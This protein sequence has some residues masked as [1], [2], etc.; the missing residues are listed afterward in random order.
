MQND[1]FSS[2]THYSQIY[3]KKRKIEFVCVC[4]LVLKVNVICVHLCLYVCVSVRER[5]ERERER[6]EE[7][8]ERKR[9]EREAC[10]QKRIYTL[11]WPLIIDCKLKCGLRVSLSGPIIMLLKAF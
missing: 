10:A 5:E 4:L 7:E 3:L 8:R 1:G 6:G 11:K 2:C 9:G